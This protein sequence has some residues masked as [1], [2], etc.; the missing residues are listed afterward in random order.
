MSARCRLIASLSIAG[1][2][3]AALPAWATIDNLKS[4]KEAYPG[5]EPKAYSCKVCHQGVMGKKDNLNTY[6]LALQK[7][8]GPGK[9]LKLIEEDYRAIEQ[10]DADEDGVSNGDELKAGTDPADAASK[11]AAAKPADKK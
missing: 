8:K 11:P 7:H 2:F 4:F 10:E 3:C 9:A 1:F 5:K 6:G